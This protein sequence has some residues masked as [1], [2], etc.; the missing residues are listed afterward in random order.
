M[1]YWR[2]LGKWHHWV[3]VLFGASLIVLNMWISWEL[4]TARRVPPLFCQR[5]GLTVIYGPWDTAFFFFLFSFD[6]IIFLL[7]LSAGKDE[8][9]YGSCILY[10]RNTL[11]L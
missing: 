5:H 4:W 7:V 3:F 11:V 6:F 9:D 8:L 1:E 2:E 10:L